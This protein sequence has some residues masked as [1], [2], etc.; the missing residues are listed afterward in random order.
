MERSIHHVVDLNEVDTVGVVE[1]AEELWVL[2]G[3]GPDMMSVLQEALSTL[4]LEKVFL[5]IPDVN[6][7][8]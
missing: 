4:V 7:L 3:E 8:C 1:D 6:I 5:V 2:A